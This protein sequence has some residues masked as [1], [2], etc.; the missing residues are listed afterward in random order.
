MWLTKILADAEA[1]AFPPICITCGSAGAAPGFDLCGGCE[2]DLPLWNQ[3]CPPAQPHSKPL[4]VMTGAGPLDG[5]WSPFL[6]DFPVDAMI[7]ELKFAGQL[8]F[9]SVL[10]AALARR[11]QHDP[12][13]LAGI[14]ALL[15]VPLHASRLRQRGFNQAYEIAR[16]LTT[17][18]PV[19][20]LGGAVVRCRKTHP[21]TLLSAEQRL[22]N[23]QGAFEVR[24]AVGG[25]RLALL[26]DVLTT[27]ATMCEL[28][29]VLKD[30]GAARVIGI[31]VAR[32]A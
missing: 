22:R 4:P 16:T 1:W 8:A 3:G 14:D 28:A 23:L 29:R 18:L 12:Q 32:A 15:P 20:L 13:P 17:L 30:A 24:H 11:L 10:G 21:Q 5:L 25:L 9:A 2:A 27:G 7:R 6:Y 19:P 26:D 31:S